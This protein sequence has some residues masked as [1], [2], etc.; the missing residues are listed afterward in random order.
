MSGII[1]S[2]ILPN[3][4]LETGILKEGVFG[5]EITPS[6]FSLLGGDGSNLIGGDSSPILGGDQ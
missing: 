6:L 3:N 2:L 5:G 4:V 1:S